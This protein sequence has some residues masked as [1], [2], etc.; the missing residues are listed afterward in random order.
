MSAQFVEAPELARLAGIRHAFFTRRGGAS[1]GI[2]ASL[3]CGPGSADDAAAVQENRVRA[4]AAIGVAEPHLTTAWQV[5]GREVLALKEP[6]A[7]ANRPKVDG[8]VTDR[9]GIGLGILAADCTPVLFADAAAG[10]VGA[11]HAGWKGALAGITDATVEAMET[12]GAERARIIAAI[13]PAIRQASYEVG[14]ELRAA[15]LAPDTA[16]ER[17]F[18]PSARTGHFMFDLTGYVGARLR[19]AGLGI[20]ADL[21]LDT[22]SDPERFY[23]YRRMTLAGEAD[24][25]RQLSAITLCG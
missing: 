10:V 6:I 15:F 3:N 2:Y 7:Q 12:L 16:A 24:Y 17:F 20:V 14:P 9:P 13:G 5:H 11:C 25:G 22:R 1:E 19:A 18:A 23:S 8:F 4:A 21:G